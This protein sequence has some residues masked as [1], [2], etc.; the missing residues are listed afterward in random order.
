MIS[1]WSG[2]AMEYAFG[3]EK[4]V[5]FIDLPPKV[6]NPEYARIGYEPLEAAIREKIGQVLSVEQIDDAG[7]IVADFLNQK[8]K[9]RARIIRARQENIYHFG[10]SAEIGAN[11]ILARL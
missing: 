8:E 1:D 10:R 5:L 6:H 7:A 3:T 2:A 9:Y 11:Y 4:P